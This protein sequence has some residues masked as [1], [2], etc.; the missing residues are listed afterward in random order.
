MP[1]SRMPHD[2]MG[3]RLAKTSL[4]LG[5][6]RK[7]RHACA[8]RVGQDDHG[9]DKSNAIEFSDHGTAQKQALVVL[10]RATWMASVRQKQ[11]APQRHLIQ[12]RQD[13]VLRETVRC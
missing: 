4:G 9:Q 13:R 5:P 8:G 6:S 11:V 10:V 2:A 3:A 12:T 7:T 1:L